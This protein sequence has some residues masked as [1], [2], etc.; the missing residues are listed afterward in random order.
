MKQVFPILLLVI[1]AWWQS[2]G[3][4]APAP[5]QAAPSANGSPIPTEQENARKAKALLDQAIEALGGPAYLGIRTRSQQGRTYSLHHGQSTSSGILFWS[6]FEFPDNERIELTKERD[7]TEIFVGDKGWEVTYKGVREQ[8][9]K[10]LTDYLRRRKFSLDVVL[11]TWVNDPTVALFYDGFATAAHNPADQ[12]TLIN[13][14]DEGV[15]LYLDTLTHLPIKKTFS[16]RD[17]VDRQKNVEEEVYGN[18]RLVGGVMTAWDVTRYFNGD[19]SGERFL[20]S[21]SYNEKLDPAMFDPHSG[22]DPNKKPS[23]KH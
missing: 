6:F 21:V 17:P 14:K 10:D 9:P 23:G 16:W 12:V 18:Y 15:D 13:S 20:N 1:S 3:G 22:Y 4:S 8:E 11:R 5:A 19:M 2:T 7:V